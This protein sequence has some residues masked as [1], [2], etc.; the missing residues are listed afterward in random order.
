M[1]IIYIN[2]EDE[3]EF[4]D[5][6]EHGLEL[7]I[8]PCYVPHLVSLNLIVPHTNNIPKK[9]FYWISFPHLEHN[10]AFRKN[11]VHFSGHLYIF[12]T[13]PSRIIYNLYLYPNLLNENVKVAKTKVFTPC[14]HIYYNRVKA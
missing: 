13:N 3:N 2:L 8:A 12:L 7:E 14:L 6:E 11:L 10:E 5:F 1:I 4:F 9:P